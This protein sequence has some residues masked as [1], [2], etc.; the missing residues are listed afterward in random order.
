MKTVISLQKTF[1]NYHKH[2]CRGEKTDI[3]N[4]AFK[5]KKKNSRVNYK[6]AVLKS[7]GEVIS[8]EV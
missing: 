5:K 2:T 8:V 6:F 4:P 3:Y 1:K 7:L